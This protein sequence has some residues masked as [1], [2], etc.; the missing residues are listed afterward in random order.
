MRPASVAVLWAGGWRLYQAQDEAAMGTSPAVSAVR[1]MLR[2]NLSACC[3]PVLCWAMN[4]WSV[5]WCL[6]PTA[7]GNP[8]RGSS[9]CCAD[10]YSLFE[11]L[12]RDSVHQ[13]IIEAP[14][15]LS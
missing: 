9:S 4:L 5:R 13:R 15:S 1:T 12:N 8:E 14:T 2:G 11:I 3:G 7:F 6:Q 10:G